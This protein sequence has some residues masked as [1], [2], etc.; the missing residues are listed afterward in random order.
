MNIG[1]AEK[2]IRQQLN[3]LY[4]GSESASIA[5][6]LLEHCTTF[7]ATDIVLHREQAMTT[8]QEERLEAALQRLQ[9]A[10][11]LQYITNKAWFYGLELYV[12]KNVLIPRPET[13]ELVDWVV[14]DVKASGKDVFEKGT[15]D[16]DATT[17]LKIVDVGTGS[18]CIALAVKKAM[19]KAEVWGC[20]VNEEA[21]NVARRNGSSL[22]VRV[23]F[24]G[25]NFLDAPQQKFLP[26]VDI[27][28]SNPPYIPLVQKD[29]L[30]PNVVEHE[31]HT[32]LFVQDED[33]L[34][35][36]KA[37]AHF[38]KKRLYQNGAIYVEVHED[39]SNE[40]AAVFDSTG[41][42]AVELKKDMQGKNRMLKAANG[43]GEKKK[44]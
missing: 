13:E 39:L 20:D 34:I 33:P 35:F 31:P 17:S 25:I 42:R 32:A 5:L 23:D 1:E 28:I 8:E 12:D 7:T 6:L 29:S 36:Y 41:Y 37:I 24:Q 18:G 3:N 10:E 11:P 30:H 15:T 9:K 27:I 21:L 4:D 14:R 38:G 22:N 2:H 19:P 40:A 44:Y 16:A 43:L 26:T